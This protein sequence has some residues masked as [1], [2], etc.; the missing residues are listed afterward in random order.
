[1]VAQRYSGNS[2]TPDTSGPEESTCMYIS[3]VSLFQ[4]FF[5]YA[6]TVQKVRVSLERET[7]TTVTYVC[8]QER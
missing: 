5:L 6:R 1:M 7:Y 8:M 4:G 3:E 2:S